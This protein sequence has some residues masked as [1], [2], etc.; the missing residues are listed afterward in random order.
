MEDT[1]YPLKPKLA[2]M[3]AILKTFENYTMEFGQFLVAGGRLAPVTV[4]QKA[5]DLGSSTF[6]LRIKTPSTG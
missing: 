2:V 4:L 6:S 3:S 5:L 1:E